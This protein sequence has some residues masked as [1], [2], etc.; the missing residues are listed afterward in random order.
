MSKK[1]LLLS[2]LKS[3][4]ERIDKPMALKRLYEDV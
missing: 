3:L 1:N 4:N 2:K